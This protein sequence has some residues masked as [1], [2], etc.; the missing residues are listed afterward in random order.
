MKPTET[1]ARTTAPDGA[2]MLLIRRD[3]VYRLMLDGQELMSSRAHGSERALAERAL[4]LLAA[5]PS[6][7][8][9]VGG[10]GCGYTLRAA[11]DAAPAGA[12]V[13]VCEYFELVV[14]AYRR[15]LGELTGQALDDPLVR[16]ER[17]DLRRL[18]PSREPFDAILLD[19]DN[20][21]WAFT[22]PTNG[23]LYSPAGLDRLFKSLAPGGV[24]AVWS[25]EPCPEFTDRLG[26][27]GFVA[28]QERVVSHSRRHWLFFGQ[29]SCLN[30]S[31]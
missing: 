3:G 25:A 22:L 1:L 10:L 12:R 5:D 26:R 16:L 19:V 17:T 8:I 6:P 29:R 30:S 23:E 20:G 31:R 14:E 13:V 7:R 15:W 2:E 18:L 9:L 21:P 28:S 27:A 4:A 24:L 11:L